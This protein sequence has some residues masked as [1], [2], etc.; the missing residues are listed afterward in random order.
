MVYLATE[1]VKQ[2]VGEDGDADYDADGDA[3]GGDS[4]DGSGWSLIVVA[5]TAPMIWF[6]ALVVVLVMFAWFGAKFDACGGFAGGCFGADDGRGCIGG[7]CRE[8][9][10]GRT[11]TG[12]HGA[13]GW[14]HQKSTPLVPPDSESG[15]RSGSRCAII[16]NLIIAQSLQQYD[17]SQNKTFV[18]LAD[19]IGRLMLPIAQSLQQTK[20]KT[21]HKLRLLACATNKPGDE[22]S[23]V[24][25]QTQKSSFC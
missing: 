2:K 20:H 12:H 19:I 18:P 4:V 3:D 23:C 7:G 5:L 9:T 13:T 6:F 10:N 21:I 25:S 17:P 14:W 16:G 22:N 15:A 11:P 24:E 1:M 8:V